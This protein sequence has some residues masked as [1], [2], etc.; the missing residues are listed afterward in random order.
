MSG[1]CFECKFMRQRTDLEPCEHCTNVFAMT[2]IH[3]NFEAKRKPITNYDLLIRKTP[4][5]MA[6]FMV[7]FMIDKCKGRKCQL[8]P[9]LGM[10]FENYVIQSQCKKCWLNWLMQEA[11]EVA[12]GKT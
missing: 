11:K 12:N 4:E 1:T 10:P 3:P 9:L 2:G 5:E 8:P 6:E 7:E